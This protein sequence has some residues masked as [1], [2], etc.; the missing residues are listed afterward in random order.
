MDKRETLD[1]KLKII[2]DIN[3]SENKIESLIE[4]QKRHVDV[5]DKKIIQHKSEK[6]T[7]E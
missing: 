2:N 7:D 5:L 6:Q 4:S 3:S 1:E